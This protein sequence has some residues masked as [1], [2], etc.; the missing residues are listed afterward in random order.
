MKSVALEETEKRCAEGRTAPRVSLRDIENAIATTIYSTVDKLIPSDQAVDH[1]V[2]DALEIM[3]LCV[4]VMANG[5]VIVGKSAPAS[6][7]NFDAELGKEL[8]YKDAV[9]QIWPLMGYALKNHLAQEEV[10]LN[11]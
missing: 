5:F 2:Y 8:A 3:T 10:I 9:G 11:G 6:R 7:D 1:K 4:I